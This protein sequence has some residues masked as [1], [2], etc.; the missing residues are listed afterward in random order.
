MPPAED[1]AEV[2]GVPGEEHLLYTYISM[3]LRWMTRDTDIHI[4]LMAHIHPSMAHSFVVHTSMVHL[5]E[6]QNPQGGSNLDWRV[7]RKRRVG[8]MSYK[9]RLV[10]A[11]WLSRTPG[12]N[13]LAAGALKISQ[14]LALH[15]IGTRVTAALTSYLFTVLSSSSFS[16]YSFRFP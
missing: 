5:G 11:R 14:T 12:M 8:S 15:P 3:S 7:S 16:F 13:V 9:V 4:T 2:G 1:D 10:G 6:F